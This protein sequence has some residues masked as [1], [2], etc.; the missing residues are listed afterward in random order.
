[1]I[2]SFE[3]WKQYR[4]DIVDSI[5]TGFVAYN[6]ETHVITCKIVRK[7]GI[8]VEKAIAAFDEM[9]ETRLEYGEKVGAKEIVRVIA[10]DLIKD[11]KVDDYSFGIFKNYIPTQ[12]AHLV[13]NRL[14]KDTISIDE[15]ALVMNKEH[16]GR[17]TDYN[18]VRID[19]VLSIGKPLNNGDFL[20]F[21]IA[22][23]TTLSSSEVALIWNQNKIELFNHMREKYIKTGKSKSIIPF[24]Y[25]K[26]SNIGLAKNN[27]L[28]V[29]MILKA[30][31]LLEET[32]NGW[33]IKRIRGWIHRHR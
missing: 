7:Q 14:G 1:M 28:Q 21:E 3:I 22:M 23:R 2:Y 30:A 25:Y 29:T 16:I 24:E 18:S 20:T 15:L 33:W 26:I 8:S 17:A 12:I 32:S 5:L 4:Y 27:V 13:V 19:G 6:S 11:H 9:K 10:D 31:D